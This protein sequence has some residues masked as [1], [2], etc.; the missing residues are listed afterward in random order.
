[1]ISSPLEL[2][3]A[4]WRRAIP[5]GKF[6]WNPNNSR[7]SQLSNGLFGH[8]GVDIRNAEEIIH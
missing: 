4:A 8:S 3:S 1:M 7:V 6:Q 2:C 5:T